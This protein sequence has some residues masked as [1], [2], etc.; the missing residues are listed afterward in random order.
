MKEFSQRL[1]DLTND[2]REVS[3]ES[4]KKEMPSID[5]NA[6]H[7]PLISTI[8]SIAWRAGNQLPMESRIHS[9]INKLL[10]LHCDIRDAMH[11]ETLAGLRSQSALDE[12]DSKV[13]IWINELKHVGSLCSPGD[14]PQWRRKDRYTVWTIDGI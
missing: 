14:I 9:K 3:Q 8:K 6:I 12:F 1:T 10:Q 7:D 2:L 5:Y 11:R 13:T 4:Q